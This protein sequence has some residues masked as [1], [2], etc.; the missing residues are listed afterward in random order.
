LKNW[1]DCETRFRS[2]APSLQNTRLDDQ[3]GAAGEH[4]RLAGSGNRETEKQFEA[5]SALAGKLLTEALSGQAGFEAIL[6]HDDPKV[7]W[8]RAMKHFSGAHR[9]GVVAQQTND[10]GEN[11]GWIYAG[12]MAD[13]ANV[14]GN[15]CLCLQDKFPIRMPWYE[16][17][18]QDYGKKIIIGLVLILASA[19]IGLWLK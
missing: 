15:V 3:G 1:F 17:V 10:A 16:K 11:L 19:L 7:R 8:Y 9:A 12:S 18:Y 6:D 4:W 5:L 13:I 2:L 14:S